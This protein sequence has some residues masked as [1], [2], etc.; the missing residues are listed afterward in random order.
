MQTSTQTRTLPEID[1]TEA[2]RLGNDILHGAATAEKTKKVKGTPGTV[3]AWSR[4]GNV[5]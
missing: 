4:G 1:V 2:A 5:D 3:R